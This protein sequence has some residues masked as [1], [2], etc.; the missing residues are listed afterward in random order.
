MGKSVR[1]KS[2]HKSI[3]VN[4]SIVKQVVGRGRYTLYQLSVNKKQNSKA[5]KSASGKK[6]S[7]ASSTLQLRK[8]FLIQREEVNYDDGH[9]RKRELT[10]MPSNSATI[11]GS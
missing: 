8:L 4:K 3:H 10:T 2:L 11:P 5:S 9:T 1:A 6:R 7:R